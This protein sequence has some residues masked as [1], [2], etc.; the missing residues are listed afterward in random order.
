[1]SDTR[2]LRSIIIRMSVPY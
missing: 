2:F 1:M